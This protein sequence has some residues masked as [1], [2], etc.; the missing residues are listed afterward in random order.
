[1]DKI[2]V[3]G[4]VL[5][6][7]R[8]GSGPPLVLMHGNEAD[9]SMFDALVD[10]LSNDFT[11]YAYDQRDCG[12]TENPAA[13]YRLAD[14]GEDAAALIEIL[15]LGRAHVYG[16]SLGGLV[17]QS[18]AARHPDR[19]ERLVLGSTWPAGLQ[20]IDFN[21]QTVGQLSALSADPAENASQIAELFFP[22]SFIRE[23]PSI[24]A[25]FRPNGRSQEMRSRRSAVLRESASV[26]LSRF[27]RPVLVLTGK[28]DEIIPSSVTLGI[29]NQV[30]RAEIA[31][32]EGIGHI[33]AIQDPDQVA[34][35]LAGF[36]LH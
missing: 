15:G 18:L 17:A 21:P 16:S 8:R 2:S 23:R 35:V 32:L 5:A 24:V 30:S 9:H 31:E 28:L 3:N 1:V 13:P 11:V 36:L 29:A 12:L 20:P 10:R 25:L 27:S 26:D 14:L 7:V 4:V 6:F 34:R 19:I 22:A 33:P